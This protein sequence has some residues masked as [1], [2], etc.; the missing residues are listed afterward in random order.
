MLL[1]IA[2][3]GFLLSW[4]DITSA[5]TTDSVHW[6]DGLASELVALEFFVERKHGT[7]RSGVSVTDTSSAAVEGTWLRL[8]IIG[9]GLWRGDFGWGKFAIVAGAANAGVVHGGVWSWFVGGEAHCKY[10]WY[11]GIW[12]S[13]DVVY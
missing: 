11:E 8:D 9:L 2:A 10:S 12:S 6:S 5:A 13:K 3:D 7:L 4:N 1:T